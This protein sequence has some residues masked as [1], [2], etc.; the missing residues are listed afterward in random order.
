MTY[1]GGLVAVVIILVAL[2]FFGSSFAAFALPFVVGGSIGYGLARF[3]TEVD[4]PR[5]VR[6][7]AVL[8]A[9]FALITAGLSLVI[10][11]VNDGANWRP[12][13]AYYSPTSFGLFGFG[14]VLLSETFKRV[15]FPSA[16]PTTAGEAR[17]QKRQRLRGI[18]HC[19]RPPVGLLGI[20]LPCAGHARHNRFLDRR[21]TRPGTH[22][23]D[24]IRIASTEPALAHL[25]GLRECGSLAGRILFSGQGSNVHDTPRY[26]R[27]DG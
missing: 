13:S 2:A 1:A 24:K 10:P 12:V 23:E 17:E 20:T 11:L 15:V 7:V 8:V 26:V 14:F 9:A 5:W 4:D 18:L 6:A 25:S 3:L 16:F 27:R 22:P 21:M 19:R